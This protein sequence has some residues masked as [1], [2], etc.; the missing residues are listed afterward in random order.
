M[1]RNR[2]SFVIHFVLLSTLFLSCSEETEFCSNAPEVDGIAVDLA[3]TDFTND[4]ISISNRN[5]AQQFKNQ[6]PFI[7]SY[8]LGGNAIDSDS[9]ITERLVNIFTNSAYKDTVYAE[10]KEEF[11]DFQDLKIEFEKAFQYYKY[12]YPKVE[13]PQLQ[14][15]LSGLQKDLYV[16]DSLVSIAADYFLGPKASYVPA[17]VPD[18]ILRRYQKEYIVPMTMLLLTQKQN[19]TDYSDKTLLADMIFYGKSYYLAKQTI[20]CTADSL[21][22]GYTS[23][24]MEDIAKNEHIIWAN[25]LENDLLYETSHFLKDKFIGERPKTFEIS[26]NCPGRIGVWVGWQ[27]INAYMRNNPEVSVQ[28][29]MQ[30]TN[31]QEI[32]A[33]SQ[34]KPRG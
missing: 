4:L 25:F 31:V 17:G 8:F 28:E 1:Q 21:L 5:D 9:A 13:A 20:P 26:N 34:Y 18:Y 15:V 10:V 16:S 11:G 12:Y 23:T 2:N 29:L 27:I 6:Y 3:L 7:T 30:K 32:F 14:M 33:Q 24:E 19:K 22:I